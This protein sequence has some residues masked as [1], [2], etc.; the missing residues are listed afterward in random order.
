MKLSKTLISLALSATLASG[1]AWSGWG[2]GAG[3]GNAAP[4]LTGSSVYQAVDENEAA[5]LT[6]MRE[7]E[8]MARDMYLN[9]SD[10]W[11]SALFRN[12]AASEQ[13]HMDAVAALLDKYGLPD[14][15]D[16]NAIGWYADGALQ[17]LFDDLSARAQTAYQVAL[18]VAALI[19]EVDIEDNRNAILETD[20]SDLQQ[21][22]ANLLRGSR[23][24]LRAYV[25]EIERLGVVYTA[26]YLDQTVVD[27][28]VDSPMERGGP[29][30]N[31]EAPGRNR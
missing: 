18:L 26:Q 24:H 15:A 21:L 5:T 25:A 10:L 23:N 13:R 2:G 11:D 19:E 28:I 4:T 22:Y 17:Q 20:N 8:K 9:M 31:G 27:E 29:G 16:P 14:P 3:G 7:E 1:A 12:I 6:F 30:G